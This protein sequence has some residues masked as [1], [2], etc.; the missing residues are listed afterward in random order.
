ML[1]QPRSA[2]GR[3]SASDGFGEAPCRGAGMSAVVA[4]SG[5][6]G[7]IAARLALRPQQHPGLQGPA[8]DG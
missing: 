1:R 2:P 4:K 5:V 7:V 6:R 3:N 8:S